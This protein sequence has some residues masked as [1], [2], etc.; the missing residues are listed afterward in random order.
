MSRRY[1]ILIADNNIHVRNFLARELN[2]PE[3]EVV[4]A[5]NHM[6][7]FARIFGKHTPDLIVFDM[8]IP[9]INSLDILKQIQDITPPIPVIIYT[10]LVEYETHPLVRKTQGFVQKNGDIKELLKKIACV[11]HYYTAAC[12]SAEVNHDSP[13]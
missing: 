1:T 12:G 3:Y 8:D 9:Y 10:Y 7:L 6:Q 5:A 11:L 2:S 13:F 4:S